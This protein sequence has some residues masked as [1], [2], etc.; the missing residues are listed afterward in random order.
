MT[1]QEA[2]DHPW[3]ATEHPELTSRIPASRYN[4]IRKQIKEKY[5]S[6]EYLMHVYC[7]SRHT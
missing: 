5:V 4:R 7:T 1:V 2:L 3:L 6:D